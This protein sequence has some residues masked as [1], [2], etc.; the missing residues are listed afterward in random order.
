MKKLVV[1]I[2]LS[3]CAGVHAQTI[4]PQLDNETMDLIIQRLENSGKLDE[5]LNKAINRKIKADKEM[6]ARVALEQEK[7]NQEN[8]KLVAGFN[9]NEHYLGDKNARY[10]MIVYE[11]LECPYC[12][13][14]AEIPEKAI[15]KLKDVNFISRANPLPFHMPV[16]GRE[17]LVA[18]CVA[19]ELGNEGY[20]KI[21]RLIFKNTLK[22]GQGL[23][24][25]SNNYRFKGNHKEIAIFKD[26]NPQEKSL[27]ALAKDIGIKDISSIVS[28]YKNPQSSVKLENLVKESMKNGITGTPT[29]ILK[30]NKTNKSAMMAGVM[31]EEDLVNK[32]N[33]FME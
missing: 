33:K 8:A 29:I 32:V 15:L 2:A 14:F 17:A 27:F 6:Q 21:T 31:S 5:A 25:L 26:L 23:P 28:C 3:V 24:L 1:L 22:N 18:E 16:A 19:D 30:D 11:D 10:S 7:R 13:V 20:F 12:Q 9:K 4:N